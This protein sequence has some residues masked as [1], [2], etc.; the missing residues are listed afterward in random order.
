MARYSYTTKPPAGAQIKWGHPLTNGLR[1][2]FLFNEMSG[3]AV[4]DA[5]T[6]RSATNAGTQNWTRGH[7]AY[8]GNAASNY[9]TLDD[10]PYLKDCPFT[11]VTRV[12]QV[13]VNVSGCIMSMNSSGTTS[14]TPGVR[15]SGSTTLRFFLFGND[16]DVT[17]PSI[18]DRVSNAVCVLYSTGTM[19][20]FEGGVSRGTRASG[21]TSYA[22]TSQR[23]RLGGQSW[24]GGVNNAATIHHA[25][26]YNRALS[27]AEA[28]W[29][30]AEPYDFLVQSP[31]R[32][33]F[34][35]QAAPVNYWMPPI[36][37]P[38]TE[39]LIAVPY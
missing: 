14:Q 31:V 12:S 15:Y 26:I 17:I 38:R 5:V 19:E 6:G 37:Q 29:V 24:D 22:A 21:V 13:T 7:G 20:V 11:F 39:R 8:V 34:I 30:T 28:D 18:T 33:Y 10:G 16:L 9:F 2:C 1:G 35:P 27:A 23:I 36:A 4:R 25:Y 32:R 3:R